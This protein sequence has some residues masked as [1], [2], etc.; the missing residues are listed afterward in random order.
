MLLAFHATPAVV[1]HSHDV[2]ALIEPTERTRGGHRPNGR[3]R[4]GVALAVVLL[5]IL[6]A[7]AAGLVLLWPSGAKQQSPLHFAADG[8]TFPRGK[9]PAMTTGPC[10]KGDMGSQNPTPL[11][12]AGKA[13]RSV[14]RPPSPSRKARPLATPYASRCPQRTWR[15]ESA[16]E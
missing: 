6:A 5:P 16:A 11:P 12:Q 10:A 3:W 1:S 7:T 4:A 9:V 14:A 8:V 2:T 13:P 15:P